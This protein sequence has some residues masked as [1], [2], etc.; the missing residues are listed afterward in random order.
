[1]FL[2]TNAYLVLDAFRFTSF[3]AVACAASV[4]LSA[5]ASEQAPTPKAATEAAAKEEEPPAAASAGRVLP[6]MFYF[7]ACVACVLKYIP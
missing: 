1:M 7:R 3:V 6:L 4:S 2:P 5:L